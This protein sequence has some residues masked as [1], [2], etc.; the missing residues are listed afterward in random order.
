MGSQRIIPKAD[1]KHSGA[2]LIL[3]IAVSS[4]VAGL[5][6]PGKENEDVWVH[7][8]RAEDRPSTTIPVFD[9]PL[10]PGTLREHQE[11]LQDVFENNRATI[12]NMDGGTGV[13]VSRDG[14]VLTLNHVVED[15]PDV[16][17]AIVNANRRVTL[18]KLGFDW[19]R[20]LAM[21]KIESNE[22][23]PFAEMG[24]SVVLQPGQWGVAMS[25]VYYVPNDKPP[26]AMLGRVLGTSAQWVC[27][28]PLGDGGSCGGGFFDLNG[29]L[30][31]IAGGGPN[32][33]RGVEFTP[34]DTFREAWSRLARGDRYGDPVHIN[35]ALTQFVG[36]SLASGSNRTEIATVL[37]GSAAEAAGLKMFDVVEVVNGTRIQM[38]YEFIEQLTVAFRGKPGF[39]SG[40]T[41]IE[42]KTSAT[43]VVRRGSDAVDLVINLRQ[44][45]R[46]PSL[47]DDHAVFNGDAWL[48][49]HPEVEQY[50]RNM[51]KNVQAFR[52]VTSEA[53]ESIVVVLVD[54]TPDR[55]GTVVDR[56]GSIATA[57]AGLTGNFTC[58]LSD[59]ETKGAKLIHS[60]PEH[61]LAILRVGIAD[62]KPIPWNRDDRPKVGKLLSAVH[63]VGTPCSFG[64]VS[65]EVQDVRKNFLNQIQV[66]QQRRVTSVRSGS[67][68]DYAGALPGD[69][70]VSINGVDIQTEKQVHQLQA[71]HPTG[72]SLTLVV[73]RMSDDEKKQMSIQLPAFGLRD[74]FLH[75]ASIDPS[76]VGGPLIG[77][78]GLAVG[79]SVGRTDSVSS[80]GVPR[81][82]VID[83]LDKAV[84]LPL[85]R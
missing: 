7:P 55:L 25:Y 56:E 23:W 80:L 27:C 78:D 62:L 65:A 12:V 60:S 73:E 39:R 54:G 49:Q 52:P 3:M 33:Q 66:T 85:I 77:I 72:G 38:K 53:S 1:P 50:Q 35:R 57:S 42:P 48:N 24:H 29:K 70:I 6:Q 67:D 4:V 17:Q 26:L 58:R 47:E 68:F 13:I 83:V 69:R 59:G 71:K 64:I 63:A 18:R 40:R 21:V 19:A 32:S 81:D 22:E 16:F 28:D 10:T 31:A 14:H 30:I 44:F 75:D 43:L 79:I 51:V 74:V 41:P 36:C 2:L 82:V 20:D 45:H 76:L 61:G 34:V 84:G 5:N 11:R 15:E 9:K 37:P 8:A 46:V